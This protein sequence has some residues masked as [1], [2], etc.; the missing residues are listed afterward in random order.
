[1]LNGCAG[2]LAGS[3]IEGVI[4]GS[5]GNGGVP[6]DPAIN[7]IISGHTHAEY[8]CTYTTGGVTRIVTSASAFGRVLTDASLTIDDVTGKPVDIDAT[9]II[10][11]NSTNVPG[12]GANPN[13]TK[14]SDPAVSAVVAQYAAQ[15]APLANSV[16]G[17]V[18]ADITNTANALGEIPSGDLIAD[19]QLLATQPAGKGGAQI[20]FMN[21]GGIRGGSSAGFLFNQISAGEQPGEITYAEAFNIQPF[22]NSLVVKTMTGAMIRSLLEQ[23]FP[24]CGGQTTQ[25]ILQVSQG[26][27]YDIAPSAGSCS[28]KIGQIRFNGSPI[29]PSATYRVTMNSFLAT[30]GDGFTVFNQGTDALGGDVDIDALKAYFAASLPGAVPAPPVNRLTLAVAPVVP[31]SPYGV[32]LPIGAGAVIALFAGAVVVRRRRSLGAS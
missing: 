7:L 9:N 18:S 30:G 32:L 28:A 22:G 4:Q 21:P 20:A 10:V 29:D 26:F 31:E 8:R 2:N 24:G 14:P 11:E 19:A 6:L 3:D 12:G 25:R 16:I 15:S 23:Q 5:S 1:V 27:S 13:L 17:K